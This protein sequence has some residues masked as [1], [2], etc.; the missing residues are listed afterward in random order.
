MSNY[1]VQNARVNAHSYPLEDDEDHL[2]IYNYVP[3]KIQNDFF[4][5]V[6]FFHRAEFKQ[7]LSLTAHK[8]MQKLREAK[9]DM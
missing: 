8:V 3:E 4:E 1:F 6:Y 9:I 7:K 2:L 5:Q